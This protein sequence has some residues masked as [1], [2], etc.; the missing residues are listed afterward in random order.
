LPADFI[1]W[2]GMTELLAIG[3]ALP[4]DFIGWLF[5]ITLFGT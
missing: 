1:G 5:Y 3:S 4:A 2:T